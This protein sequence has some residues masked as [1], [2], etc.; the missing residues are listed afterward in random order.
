MD[1]TVTNCMDG[2]ESVVP[3]KV[4]TY[5]KPHNQYM[6]IPYHS[7]HRRGVFKGFIKAELQRYAVTN[8]QPADFD[9][10]TALFIQHL[11]HR[12]YPVGKLRRWFAAVDHSCSVGLL[13]RPSKGGEQRSSQPPVLVLP[14][15]QLQMTANNAAVL[16]RVYAAYK[17]HPAVATIFGGVRQQCT[18]TDCC[19]LQEPLLRG[20]FDQGK[21]L[22]Q[23]ADCLLCWFPC[24]KHDSCVITSLCTTLT[25]TACSY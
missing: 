24:L 5:Q 4:T 17:Q 12:G 13:C 8:T 25:F 2:A 11:V 1:L 20:A 23:C 19:I 3:L 21:A 18:V 10:M 15:G 7:F 16:N 6:Y 22:K 9:G 14:N